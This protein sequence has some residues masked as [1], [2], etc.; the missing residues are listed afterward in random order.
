MVNLD[1]QINV[2]S[3]GTLIYLCTMNDNVKAWEQSGVE[4]LTQEIP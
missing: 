4:N 1:T 3:Q 2:L